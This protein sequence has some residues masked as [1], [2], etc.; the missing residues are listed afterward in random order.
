MGM[1]ICMY[2]HSLNLILIDAMKQKNVCNRSPR[3]T[4]IHC[5]NFEM[6]IIPPF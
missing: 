6:C 1:Y 4:A 5:H 3:C 2:T